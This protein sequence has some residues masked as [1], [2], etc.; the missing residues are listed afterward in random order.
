MVDGTL[1]ASPDAFQDATWEDIAPYYEALATSPLDRANVEAWL[2]DWS[3]FESLLS[4]AGALAGFA[5]SCDTSDPAREAAELRFGTQISPR[6]HEQRVRLQERL[7]Q[8]DY[9][10][11]GLE[12]MVERFRNQMRLFAP[13]NVPLF[14]DLSKL[15]TE[16]SKV[17]GAMTVEWDGEQKTPSQL[18]PFLESTDRSVRERAFKM[19]AHPYIEHR[20]VLA[21]IFDQHVRPPPAGR[22]KC[23]LR[24][25]SGL[26]PSREKSFRLHT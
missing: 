14:A 9:V 15:E 21:G 7:V 10:R 8:L 12:T 11:P 1:P 19:R 23:R 6:A 26:C 17:N 3:L 18:L 2:A 24:K 13:A 25:L 4:E 5:Y 16:W 20:G 22:T